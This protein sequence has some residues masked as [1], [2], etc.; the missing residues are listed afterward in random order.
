MIKNTNTELK[1]SRLLLFFSA[2]FILAGCKT[3]STEDLFRVDR[4]FSQ[5][6]EESGMKKAFLE[7]ADDSA[8]LLRENS[9]PIIGKTR[10]GETFS[11]F[12]DTGFILTWE[13]ILGDISRSGD[14]GYTVG[15]LA[16][17]KL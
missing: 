1:M 7:F 13:P 8:V 6:S 9:M 16:G 2:A 14:L 5:R 11:E 12:E 17:N 10:L 3:Y 4:E 15:D